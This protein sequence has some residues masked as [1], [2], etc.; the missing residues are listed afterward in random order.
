MRKLFLVFAK[1]LGLF[2]LYTV[3]VNVAPLAFMLGAFYH[4]DSATLAE[5]L[6]GVSGYLVYLAV[7]LAIAWVLLA[8][9]GWLAD[10]AGVRDET[11]VPD[12]DRV[13]AL[14]VGITLLG[15]FVTVQGIPPLARG[16]IQYSRLGTPFLRPAIWNHILP[17]GLQIALGLFLALKPA[18]VARLVAR[19]DIPPRAA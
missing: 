13:P 12:L 18:A 14:R 19:P 9:T 3:L 2:Q 7:S 17:S 16:L 11:P 10:K 5:I 15:I 1:L 6:A 4:E 8:K